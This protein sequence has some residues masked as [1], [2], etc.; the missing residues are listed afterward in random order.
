MKSYFSISLF[1]LLFL[2]ASVSQSQFVVDQVLGVVGNEKIL[3]SD[4]EQ[5]HLRMKVQGTVEE[6]DMKCKILEELMIHK[7]LLHQAALDSID[8]PQSSVDGELDRRLKYFVNQVGSEAALEKYFNKTIFQIKVDLRVTIEEALLA[9]QMQGKIVENVAVTPSEVKRF[10]RQIPKDS[11]PVIPEQYEVRQIVLN[12]PA[13]QEANYA[14]REKLL[15]IRERILKGE[16]FSTLAVAYSEDRASATR[17][18]ELGFMPR[19][20]LV[21][22]FSDVAFSL[23]D[24]QVSQIVESEYGFH[25]IQMIEHRGDEVNVRHILMTPEYSP[26]AL[27]KSQNKLDSI[28]TL[29]KND[30]ISFEHAAQRFSED[31]KTSLGGGLLINGQT[32]TSLFEREHFAPADYYVIRN[33]KPNEI[34]DPFESRN[35]HAK[36]VYKIVMVTRIVPQH[37]ANLDDDYAIIQMMA[38]SH[39]QQEVFLDWIK[40]KAKATYV[41]IDPSFLNCSFDMEGWIK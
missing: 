31:E 38:K 24:G 22:A 28:A 29:I 30:S 13:G 27:L 26:D 18:G 8:V 14:V 33:L 41:R 12:P 35:Q 16:R 40:S 15:S 2:S 39:R 17:G 3:L 9:Q 23:K 4:I 21:K 34:S 20:G 7:L 1:L 36:L 37:K 11:L 25:I 5:E 6:G 32:N 10:F 19:E